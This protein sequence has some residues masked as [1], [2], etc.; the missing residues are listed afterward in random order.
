MGACKVLVVDDAAEIRQLVKMV[1]AMNERILV[2][3]EGSNGEEAVELCQQHQPDVLVLDI[4]M[5]LMDGLQA[6]PLIREVS[7]ATRVVMLSGFTTPEIKTRAL[8]LGACTFVE[9]GSVIGDIVA[10]VTDQCD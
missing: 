7:P 3:G 5:P 8:K 2:I 6:L 9:K 10:A 4:S 1:L